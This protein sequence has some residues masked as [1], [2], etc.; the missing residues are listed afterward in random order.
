[1]YIYIYIYIYIHLYIYIYI[2][3]HLYIYT[4]LYANGRISS[5]RSG[6]NFMKWNLEL[7]QRRRAP[8]RVILLLWINWSNFLILA[9][10]FLV[11]FY[12]DDFLIRRYYRGFSRW[13]RWSFPN[14][15]FHNITFCGSKYISLLYLIFIVF[16]S[17]LFL[18]KSASVCLF[19]SDVNIFGDQ[20]AFSFMQE[21]VDIQ[22]LDCC[23]NFIFKIRITLQA[24]WSWCY[25]KWFLKFLLGCRFSFEVY[26]KNNLKGDFANFSRKTRCKSYFRNDI[27]E[28]FGETPVFHNDFTGIPHKGILHWKYF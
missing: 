1:M 21:L 12:L 6:G 25:S 5:I 13:R 9:H 2:H 23:F 10:N 14:Y 11:S 28:D 17:P 7:H 20:M 8:C 19:F 18:L 16:D 22:H 15:L 26:A 4:A 24:S 3:V 27:T